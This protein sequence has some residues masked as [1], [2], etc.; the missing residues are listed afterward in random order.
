MM[1]KRTVWLVYLSLLA[2]TACESPPPEPG[3]RI[4]KPY[5]IDGR[6]YYPEYDPTY[7]KIGEAS[8]YGP[9]FHGKY[10]AN[11]EVYNQNDL[12]AAHPTLPMPSLVRVTNLNNG[13][14]LILRI[15]D[16]GPFKSNR[17]IDLSKKAAHELGVTSTAQVRVQY[18][19]G[20][21]E[22]YLASL[23]ESGR[24]TINMAAYNAAA[25]NA[26]NT[27]MLKST[28]PSGQIVEA[29]VANSHVG[30]T[31]N[32]AAPIVTVSADELHP[33]PVDLRPASQPP[34]I[35]PSRG[36]IK[37]AWADENMPASPVETVPP[38]VGVESSDIRPPF[39]PE[40]ITAPV[41]V[42]PTV[43]PAAKPVAL[44]AIV[45]GQAPS[46]YYIQAG[47]FAAEENAR[48]LSS[49]LSKVGEVAIGKVEMGGK[50]WWRV[51]LGPFDGQQE[52]DAALS[53]VRAA[54]LSDARIVH[55]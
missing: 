20:E 21:T 29:T 55:L 44:K 12:T 32:E 50:S 33:Q 26:R 25:A 5:V 39:E 3:M 7:D 22:T 17:I 48:K 19:K 8:W 11:G 40:K 49:R 45:A 27:A 36:L 6:T 38:P 2:L 51:R 10:T 37:Q 53:K 31:I 28:E 43:S 16:R 35:K 30:Q 24:K 54:G 4:G 18:L 42:M 47:S 13:K 34:A 52:A 9:G 15:N 1:I 41:K 14:S 46:A 23:S